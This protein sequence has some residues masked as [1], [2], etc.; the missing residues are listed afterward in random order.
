MHLNFE[1]AV[2]N[3]N[4]GFEIRK[5]TL[6]IGN[7]DAVFEFANRIP[8]LQFELNIFV[9]RDVNCQ[10]EINHL[11]FEIRNLNF[12]SPFLIILSSQNIVTNLN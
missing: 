3:L 7:L 12:A 6:T 8:I 9:I 2:W 1:L 11:E 10:L 5:L 4:C